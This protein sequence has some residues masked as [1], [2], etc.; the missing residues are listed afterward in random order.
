MK[1]AIMQPYFFP[2]IG[3][4]Q[5]MSEVDKFVVYDNIKY[6][7][8]GWIRRNRILLNGHDK[9]ISLPIKNDSDFLDIKDRSISEIF[10]LKEKEKIKNLIDAGYSKAPNYDTVKPIIDRI[11][12]Q[13]ESNLFL[14]IYNSILTIKK[15]LGIDTELMISSEIN[16]NHSLRNKY[17]VIEICKNLKSDH[18]INSIG[19]AT[20]YNRNE[21]LS[22][23][24]NLMFLKTRDIIYQQFNNGF[25]PNLSIID[26]MMFNSTDQAKEL[27]KQYI[28]Q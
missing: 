16:I 26:V 28:L 11:L 24:I 1:L 10:Y 9:L 18:Y 14:F 6:T 17:K 2:Y 27:L 8:S 19:G 4:W 7:K 22:N 20:I 23:G 25:I 12:D 15:Y 5:L 21:F 3:Y 13:N